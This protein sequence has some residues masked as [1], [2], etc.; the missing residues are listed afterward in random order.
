MCVARR[1]AL[2]AGVCLAVAACSPPNV[3]SLDQDI[4]SVNDSLAEVEAELQEYSGGLIANLLNARKQT[5]SLTKDMLQR[6]RGALLYWIDLRYDV[7]GE[8]TQPAS[9]EQLEP[10]AADMAEIEAQILVAEAEARTVGGLIRGMALA[11][12]ATQK[13]SLATTQLRYYALKHG[14]PIVLPGGGAEA[15]RESDSSKIVIDDASQ[16]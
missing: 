5:L 12:V 2:A 16:L 14:V 4:R 3:D 8:L 9:A 11:Q 15:A 10:V 7:D 13:L 1:F 6:K